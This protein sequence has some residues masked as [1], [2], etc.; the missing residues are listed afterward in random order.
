MTEW[1]YQNLSSRFICFHFL[2]VPQN[3]NQ[4]QISADTFPDSA[5]IPT[6]V[7]TISLSLIYCVLCLKVP[8]WISKEQVYLIFKYELEDS[9]QVEVLNGVSLY[10]KMSMYAVNS[11]KFDN[12]DRGP[13]K[14]FHVLQ[15]IFD[16][17]YWLIYVEAFVSIFTL[18]SHSSYRNF[19]GNNLY[20]II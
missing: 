18:F 1:Q 13:L 4:I 9:L 16:Q 20:L 5:M 7:K 3:L 15:I 17:L 2:F 8:R 19:F 14:P 11:I 12:L 10:I 6:P